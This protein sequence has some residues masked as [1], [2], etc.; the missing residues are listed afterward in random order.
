MWSRKGTPVSTSTSPLPSRSTSATSW[1]SFDRRSILPFL[2]KPYL[3]RVGVC[4]Q[5]LQVGERHARLAEQLEV[6]S[7]EAGHARALQEVVHAQGRAEARRPGGRQGVVRAGDIVAERN[8]GVGT[9][10]D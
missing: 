1:V 3:H 10:E 9:D 8:R 4:C 5:S 7:V 2:L 6:A